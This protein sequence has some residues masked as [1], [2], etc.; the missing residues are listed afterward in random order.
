M[1]KRPASG[2]GGPGSAAAAP[3]RSC[4][5]LP[6][7]RQREERPFGRR[8]AEQRRRAELR[9]VT[10]CPLELPICEASLEVLALADLKQPDVLGLLLVD[11]RVRRAD[12][13][14]IG[15]LGADSVESELLDFIAVDAPSFDN[16]FLS[17]AFGLSDGAGAPILGGHEL[18]LEFPADPALVLR[19]RDEAAALRAGAVPVDGGQHGHAQRA[20]QQLAKALRSRIKRVV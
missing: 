20:G 3:P 9:P 7:R 10:E 8:D 6:A 17:R 2:S 16:A 4:T 11:A 12:D 1:P 14:T 15:Q 5:S 19:L 13:L 18:R